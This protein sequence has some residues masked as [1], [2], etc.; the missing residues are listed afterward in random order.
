MQKL[1]VL[2]QSISAVICYFPQPKI[3]LAQLE[4]QSGRQYEDHERIPGFAKIEKITFLQDEYHPKAFVLQKGSLVPLLQAIQEI[5]SAD[6]EI[7][8][9]ECHE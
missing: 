9:E 6:I 1:V 5:Q 3:P 4:E 2:N 8:V 7:T